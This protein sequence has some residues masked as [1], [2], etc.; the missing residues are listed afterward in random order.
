MPKDTPAAWCGRALSLVV[1]GH[2]ESVAGTAAG[3]AQGAGGSGAAR[4]HP[5]SEQKRGQNHTP[6]GGP[7]VL[8]GMRPPGIRVV[9]RNVSG[10]SATMAMA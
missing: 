4:G 2:P 3:N 9:G 1:E 8:P 6:K 10:F 7:L 5:V